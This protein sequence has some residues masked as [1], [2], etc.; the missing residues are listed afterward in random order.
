MTNDRRQEDFAQRLSRISKERGGGVEPDQTGPARDTSD[1]EYNV[2][3]EAHP[4]RNGIIWVIVLAA[5]GAGGFYGWQALPQDLKA[6]MTGGDADATAL[7]PEDIL[8]TETMSDQGPIFASP[9]VAH[10][11]TDPIALADVVT[12]VSLPTENTAVRGIIPIIRNAQCVLR[13]PAAG[14]KVMGVRLENALLPGP[15]HAFSDAQMVDQLLQ[16]IEAVAQDGA[17]PLTDMKLSG[18]KTVLDLFVTDTSAPLYLVLQNMGPGIVWNLHTVPDVAIAHIALIGSDFSG[19]ANLPVN[20]TTE[21]LLVSDFLPPHQ[22][23]ADDVPRDCMIRPWR[24]PQPDWIGS[25]KSEAGSLQYQ[26]QMY[27]YAGGYAA[28]NS[29]YTETLGVDARA[30]TVTAR[31]AAHVLLGPVPQAPFAY[32]SLAGQDI[33]MVATDHLMTGDFDTRTAAVAQLQDTLLRAAVG[34]DIG[35]LDPPAMERNSQ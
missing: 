7:A 29:W 26:N 28:Y 23:G 14:E 25:L 1:F 19:V 15:L 8:E 3:R 4:I 34:G 12:Q 21:A 16:N 2:P 6:M 5:L 20:A 35:A 33:H 24:T 10:A 31:D 30:D 18:E 13:S 27:S 11:G 17:D 32:N 22:Y 9:A